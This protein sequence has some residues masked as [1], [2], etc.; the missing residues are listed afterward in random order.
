[1]HHKLHFLGWTRTLAD[2]VSSYLMPEKSAGPYSLRDTILV[3]PTSES[4]RRLRRAMAKRAEQFDSGVLTGRVITPFQLLDFDNDTK[5]I[6]TLFEETAVWLDILT[7]ARCHQLSALFPKTPRDIDFA[8][9]RKAV[10]LLVDVRAQLAEAGFTSKMVAESEHVHAAEINRWRDIETLESVVIETLSGHGLKDRVAEQMEAAAHARPPDGIRRIVLC[11]C[12]EIAPLLQQL[13]GRWSA[14][15]TVE[16]LVHAPDSM[17]SAFDAWGCPVTSFW[18]SEAVIDLEHDHAQL[19]VVDTPKNQAEAVKR[20]MIE[21]KQWAESGQFAVGVPDEAVTPFIVAMLEEMGCPCFDPAG[22]PHRQHP[23]F[24]FIKA[25]RDLSGQKSYTSLREWVRLAHVLRFL[26]QFQGLS[27]GE[28]LVELDEAQN[29]CLPVNL[30]DLA[31]YIS[32]NRA[33]YPQLR[34]FIPWL[35]AALQTSELSGPFSMLD[36]LSQ[37]Y[38]Q[39]KLV[40][41]IPDDDAF[42]SVAR[43]L[44]DTCDLVAQMK[45]RYPGIR[46]ADWI[47]LL[48]ETSETRF[49]YPDT[50]QNAVELEGWLELPWNDAPLMIIT[51]MNE[52]FVPASR[53]DDLFLPDSV[54]EKL[55]LRC[56]AT[57]CAR[58]AYLLYA[59][60]ESRRADGCLVLV[61]GRNS[62][63]GD[64]LKPS[65]LFWRC[66]DDVM[67]RR[68]KI[69]FTPAALV[70]TTPERFFSITLNTTPPDEQARKRLNRDAW[71]VT[72]FSAYLKCPYSFYLTRVLEMS[73][74]DDAKEEMDDLDFGVLVHHALEIF[75][76]DPAT[77]RLRNAEKISKLLESLVHDTLM[78]TFGRRPPLVVELQAQSAVQRLRAFADL[79]VR[80]MEEGWSIVDVEKKYTAAF[81]NMSVRGKID[82]IDRHADGR[83]RV[84]DYKTSDSAKKTPESI[85]LITPRAVDSR[86]YVEIMCRFKNRKNETLRHWADLQLPFYHHFIMNE[87]GPDSKVEAG[88]LQLTKA[89]SDIKI[90][91]WPELDATLVQSAMDCAEGVLRDARAGIYGPPLIDGVDDTFEERW[92]PGFADQVLPPTIE[93]RS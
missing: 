48:L 46:D 14:S 41:G 80:D 33:D 67:V 26:Q 25:W 34:T 10:R 35:V 44:V 57:R 27:G 85:H 23:I 63:K 74:M 2:T 30:D 88:Y 29:A 7:P 54:R 87:Y 61:S 16:I 83:L 92:W 73:P 72:D 5:R 78:K 69:F 70:K 65:R 8:W 31:R 81:G 79:H 47:D 55:G 15:V 39:T 32:A 51:G 56:D 66:P 24:Q 49:L 18:Q 40:P 59:L 71:N 60:T 21:H 53:F 75:G 42:I 17:S 64:V 37:I 22:V 36:R 82:R 9:R 19:N 52:G 89:V 28:L 90:S 6:L 11:A 58:D 62:D 50:R 76:R 43:D 20:A 13:L 91:L 45:S 86:P 3:V 4:G 84:L 93:A 68:T 77:S 12:P 38:Q 1:M